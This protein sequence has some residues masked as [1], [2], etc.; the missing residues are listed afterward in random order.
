MRE[1]AEELLEKALQAIRSTEYGEYT[2]AEGLFRMALAADPM[3]WEIYYYRGRYRFDAGEYM[4]AAQDL[5]SLIRIGERKLNENLLCEV[6]LMRGKSLGYVFENGPAL[7][8]F[9]KALDLDPE[10]KEVKIE[11]G[12]T[13]YVL[14]NDDEAEA[15]LQQVKQEIQNE[16]PENFGDENTRFPDF[17]SNKEIQVN[18][19]LACLYYNQGKQEEAE[20]LLEQNS[21]F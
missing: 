20:K 4:K 8:D 13:Y 21:F 6:Y 1:K 10:N 17:P 18:A 7:F 9:K 16:K 11:L 15:L 2:K 12:Y 3:A 19:Y 14:E 5:T